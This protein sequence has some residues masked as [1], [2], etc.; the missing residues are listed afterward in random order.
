[1]PTKK[2][3]SLHTLVRGFKDTLKFSLK[4]ILDY[5]IGFS[6]LLTYEDIHIVKYF[7]TSMAL[8]FQNLIN[9]VGPV[10]RRDNLYTGILVTDKMLMTL[11][12]LA[13][14]ESFRVLSRRFGLNRG[15]VPYIV[16]KTFRQISTI[17]N[18]F[19]RWPTIDQYGPLSEENTLANTIGK[20]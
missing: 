5:Q 17:A 15:N 6:G 4:M 10:I 18:V 12:W 11:W 7:L 16:L 20:K 1:M 2:F 9:I 14:R 8:R 19:I 3:S 13:N